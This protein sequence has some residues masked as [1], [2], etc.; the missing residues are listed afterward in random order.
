LR[1]AQAVGAQVL[2][3]REDVESLELHPRVGKRCQ[4]RRHL[5]T[6]DAELLRPATEAHSRAPDGEIRI[7]PQ[8]HPSRNLQSGA[9]GL[10]AGQLADRL[11]LDGDPGGDRLGQL[12]IG[13]AGAREAHPRGCDRCIEGVTQLRARCHVEAVHLAAEVLQQGGHRIGLH[14]VVQLDI[15]G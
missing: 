12:W 6:V 13:L 3:A 9:H 14:R 1:L 7:D 10:H 5:L 11:Q 15:S 8:R 2:G 4:H